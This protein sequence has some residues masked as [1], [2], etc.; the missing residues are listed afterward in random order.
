MCFR[1]HPKLVEGLRFILQQVQNER[2]GKAW[3][4]FKIYN[5]KD[6]KK[7]GHYQFNA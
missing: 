5:E 3:V 2:K 1:A 4:E 7:R 6:N